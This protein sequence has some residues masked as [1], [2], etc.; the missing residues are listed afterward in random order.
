MRAFA[1]ESHLKLSE[2]AKLKTNEIKVTPPTEVVCNL[3]LLIKEDLRLGVRWVIFLGYHIGN[4]AGGSFHRFREI[5]R[6]ITR[7]TILELFLPKIIHHW[8]Y[9]SRWIYFL[10][11]LEMQSIMLYSNTLHLQIDFTPLKLL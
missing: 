6:K 1:F 7:F 9:H 3:Y 2:L 8:V 4:K 5:R 10:L 11:N